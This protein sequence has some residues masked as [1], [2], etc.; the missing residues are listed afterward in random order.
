MMTPLGRAA[1]E[2]RARRVNKTPQCGVFSQSA[3]RSY[4]SSGSIASEARNGG[5]YTLLLATLDPSFLRSPVLKTLSPLRT[6]C[7]AQTISLSKKG[8]NPAPQD[9]LQFTHLCCN[10]TRASEYRCAYGAPRPLHEKR[11][12]FCVLL[13]FSYVLGYISRSKPPR[14]LRSREHSRCKARYTKHPNTECPLHN[15]DTSHK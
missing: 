5:F 8:D 2:E 6:L 10:I 11:T 15:T 9:T 3:C 13:S 4:A 7:S 1:P 14:C 12:H